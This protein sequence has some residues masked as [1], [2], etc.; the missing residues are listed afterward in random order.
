MTFPG[1]FLPA[2]AVV[3]DAPRGVVPLRCM[4][5]FMPREARREAEPTST[6]KMALR[7][8]ALGVHSHGTSGYVVSTYGPI[9]DYRADVVVVSFVA[10]FTLFLRPLVLSSR[11]VEVEVGE[12][13]VMTCDGREGGVGRRFVVERGKRRL[14]LA[15]FGEFNFLNRVM[16]RLRSL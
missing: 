3:V 9:V 6:V 16:E 14:R 15:V 1:T 8:E 4:P 10:P 11:R 13:A 5:V 7:A 2:G 12:E